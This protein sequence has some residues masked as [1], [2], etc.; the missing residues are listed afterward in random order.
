MW[1]V[2]NEASG[3]WSAEAV[4]GVRAA[5]AGAGRPVARQ[6]DA[7]DGPLDPAR[8]DRAGVAVIAVL[9]GDG[10]INAVANALEGWRGA[11]LALPGG[12]A[13]LLARALHGEDD[14][15]RIAARFAALAPVRRPCI[16]WPGGAALVEV[17]AGP[18]AQWSE[19]REELRDGGVAPL[20]EKAVKAIR[21]STT[22]PLVALTD[23]PL[24]RADGYPGVRLAVGD[25]G[26]SVDG[27][28]A[29]TLGDLLKQGLA[30]LRRDFREG[31][32]DVLGT[33]PSVACRS[34]GGEP[35]ALMVDGE[36][37]E[38]AVQERF[39]LAPFALD[40]L[41]STG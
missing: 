11:L 1:L 9:A 13:N 7:R 33:H 32:H 15:A 31:P 21:Q 40:L 34:L 28:G 39:S 27:Y 10:T 19:V 2:V 22:G 36:R 5:L 24:G 4:E 26:M 17:L 18:G 16:R 20:A 8:L 25:A 6:V 29:E 35:L 37:R 38:G 30:L 23:P 41:A 14:P 12:T 3:S